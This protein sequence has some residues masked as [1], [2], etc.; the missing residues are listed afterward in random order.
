[1]QTKTSDAIAN[2]ARPT[3]LYVCRVALASLRVEAGSQ[4]GQL[5]IYQIVEKVKRECFVRCIV[6]RVPMHSKACREDAASGRPPHDRQRSEPSDHP[7]YPYHLIFAPLARTPIA[8]PHS[9]LHT[10]VTAFSHVRQYRP[11]HAR[12]PTPPVLLARPYR[13]LLDVALA[14]PASS[15]SRT[16]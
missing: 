16:Y 10:F 1:M 7:V 13:K 15:N 6:E 9:P 4:N 8:R 12:S 2:A 5:Q 11:Q 3:T 14:A